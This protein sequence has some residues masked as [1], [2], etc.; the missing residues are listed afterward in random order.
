MRELVYYIATSL[1]AYIAGPHHEV[2]VFPI[3]GDHIDAILRDYSDTL[4]GHVASA[5]G[6]TATGSVFDTVLMGW[7]TYQIGVSAGATSPYPHLRQFVFSRSPGTN[8]SPN[9]DPSL[10]ITD[11][12]PVAVTR[13]LKAEPTG[14]AVWLCGGGQ[15]ASVLAGEIDRLILKV[16]PIV[17]GAGIS[18]FSGGTFSPRTYELIG[19]TPYKSGVLINEYRRA[20]V[21]ES[22]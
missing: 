11:E 12:D 10:T 16:N 8:N 4:P 21:T 14:S 5:L 7:N 17:L 13:R 22:A 3:E 18:L 15:L 2:D 9:D 1:D 19:S 6:I 20:G